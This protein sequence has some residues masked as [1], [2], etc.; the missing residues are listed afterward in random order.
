MKPAIV[1]A[2]VVVVACA[3]YAGAAAV[4]GN[5]IEKNMR[6]MAATAQTAWPTLRLT[7]ER[8]DRGVFAATHTVTLRVGCDAPAAGASAPQGAITI[9]QHVHY[10]PLPAFKGVGAATIDTE[11]AMDAATRKEVAKVFGTE[12]PFQAHTD[13]AFGGA[14]HTR[15]SVA[16]FHEIG[17]KGEQVDFQGLAG[18]VDN[19]DGTLEYDIRMPAFSIAD[20][21]SAPAGVTVSMKGAH[22][23]AHAQG[24]GDLALRSGKSQGEIQAL[25]VAVAAPEEGGAHKIALNQFKFTQDTTIDKNLLSFVGRLE[26]TGLIDDTRLDRIELQGTMKR[27]DAIAYQDLMRQVVNTDPQSCGKPRDPAKLMASEQVQAALAKVLS[28]NPELSLDKL[29]VEVDGKR[30][31]LAYAVGIEGFTAADA[32][33][34]LAAGLMTRG[35]GN[36]R[37][38]LPEDWVQKSL[39][40][41]AQQSGK[42]SGASDQAAFAELMLAKVIDEGYVVR[43][44]GM[45]RSE[46]A[47]QAGRVT[48]NG[49]PIG[50]PAGAPDQ[51]VAA[52]PM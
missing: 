50:R 40:K 10:G 21:A 33:L 6:A 46:A 9:V 14:T 28:A 42:E 2:G 39:V 41:V 22:L 35:H 25:E 49:K 13:V 16:K 31:E 36:L 23:H 48:V 18:E 32:K 19:K 52:A 26:G 12:Q 7:D 45:L 3:A 15:F 30:A 44:E 38:R 51:P 37:I 43:E 5:K 1:A 34:P 11:V 8:Y 20:A 24:T 27:L 4:I 47:F 17:P 29:V